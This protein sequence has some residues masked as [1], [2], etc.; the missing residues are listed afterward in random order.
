VDGAD[1]ALLAV[2][3]VGAIVGWRRG[4]AQWTAF[5]LGF[6]AGVAVDNGPSSRF[7]T[8]V[9]HSV[10]KTHSFAYTI[11]A[12][13]VAHFCARIGIA[14]IVGIVC[15]Q[16]TWENRGHWNEAFSFAPF[17]KVAGAVGALDCVLVTTLV[18]CEFALL[19]AATMTS[20]NFDHTITHA[21]VLS[22]AA[23]LFH[24]EFP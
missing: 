1:W 10:E 13:S 6:A 3:A 17:S 2:M 15:H 7:A 11:D 23:R 8:W 5:T 24:L 18:S 12:T 14:L 21:T 9:S 19:L 20:I 16:L 22:H 4:A